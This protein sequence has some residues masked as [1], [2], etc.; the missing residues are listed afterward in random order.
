MTILNWFFKLLLQFDAY[1]YQVQE[2]VFYSLYCIQ[3][4]FSL[5]TQRHN[6]LTKEQSIMDLALC[7]IW[8]Q[9][10]SHILQK[11]WAYLLGKEP[12]FVN[13]TFVLLENTYDQFLSPKI[14]FGSNRKTGQWNTHVAMIWFWFLSLNL[15]VF[16]QFI[17]RQNIYIFLTEII[18]L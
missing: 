17:S 15:K 3:N 10:R 14:I 8:F 5:D 11:W 6:M 7:R 4:T 16:R 18:K 13:N 2:N 12:L 9:F 1:F